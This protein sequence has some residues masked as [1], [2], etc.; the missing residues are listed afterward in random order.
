[1][2]PCDKIDLTICCFIIHCNVQVW[3]DERVAWNPEDFGEI[4]RVDVPQNINV[5]M[6]DVLSFNQ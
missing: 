6:P 2:Y 3:T 5:W 1:M 4:R